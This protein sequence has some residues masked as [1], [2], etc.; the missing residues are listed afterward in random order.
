MP[1]RSTSWWTAASKNQGRMRSWSQREANTHSRGTSRSATSSAATNP[2][3][4]ER[5]R[6]GQFDKAVAGERVQEL[7]KVGLQSLTVDVEFALQPQEGFAH[8]GRLAGRF[9]HG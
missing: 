4:N 8:S 2:R 7:Q 5:R 1:T 9:P 3:Q 6:S